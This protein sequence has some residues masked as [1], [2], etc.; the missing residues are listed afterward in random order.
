MGALALRPAD[1]QEIEGEPRVRDL[2]LGE[3]L[4][5]S[6]PIDVRKLIRRNREQL[7]RHGAIFAIVAKIPNT[8]GR[9]SVE[10]YLNE[11]QA[12]R[13]C[14]W[15]DAAFAAAVQEQMV[16]VF[17]AYRHGQLA[18]A[19]ANDPW[20]RLEKRIAYLERLIQ[21]QALVESPEYARAIT[22]APSVFRLEK[23][24]GR[25]R[26]QRYPKFWHDMPVRA[27]V[28]ALHRQMTIHQA[29]KTLGAEFGAERAPSKSTLHRVW[30]QLDQVRGVKGSVH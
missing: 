28:I 17:F 23:P 21:A 7:E 27:A 30:Q 4:G 5:Y 3:A 25:R 20:A 18:A 13:L 15:S 1:L 10:Y 6:N 24:D 29:V 12:Y 2:R 9:P 22:Y 16:E 26:N 19:E 14:M 11:R 8:R